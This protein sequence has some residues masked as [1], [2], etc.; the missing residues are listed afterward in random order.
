LKVPKLKKKLKDKGIEVE[1]TERAFR[2]YVRRLKEDY[3]V[4]Q[5]RYYAPVIDMVPGAQAQV[6]LG[7]VRGVFIGGEAKTVY[8][9][10]MVLSF[11]RLLYVSWSLKPFNTESFIKFHD[12][13]FSY[14]Q[15]I[16]EE[17]VYDQTK[18]VV[19]KENY[20]EVWFNS[21]FYQYSTGA[22][23]NP[24]VCQAYD[25]E[26]KG[27]V[28]AA[29]K[30]IKNNF[31]Y[32]EEFSSWQMLGEFFLKWLE[33]TANVRLHGT[34]GKRP[35]DMFLEEKLYL[36]PY[37]E[38]LL[39]SDNQELRRVDKTSLITYKGNKYSVPQKYQTHQVSTEE[40]L[41]EY[42]IIRDKRDGEIIAKHI[43]SA[44]KSKIIIK[45]NHYRDFSKT[46]REEEKE[47]ETIMPVELAEKTCKSLKENNPRIYRD[48]LIGLKRVCKKYP[49]E[50]IVEVLT[51]LQN[52][53]YSLRV[54]LIEEFVNARINRKD[55]VKPQEP[56]KLTKFK[57]LQEPEASQHKLI[58]FSQIG[59][60]IV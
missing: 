42:L 33:E 60:D 13:A 45:P 16:P 48:Q 4:K 11:S 47:V 31:L 32:G 23:F 30:Y 35:Y 59:G 1:V 54:T 41:D 28:E 3:P 29:V 9:S 58:V 24:W 56:T 26:S 40:T 57:S 52:K 43:L 55:S 20:R 8:F 5:K 17:I 21:R 12:E 36:K 37:R 49:H 2:N 18:L 38:V 44:E 7:E 10:A 53:E 14:F 27:R 51:Y 15:G 34:T 50:V 6:D 39:G 25:P 22:G 46:I 19:I